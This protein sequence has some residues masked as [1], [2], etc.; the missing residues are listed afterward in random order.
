VRPV[1]L[2]LPLPLL[3][4]LGTLASFAAADRG[5]RAL[6][7]AFASV[8]PLLG[9]P[10]APG[11]PDAELPATVPASAPAPAAALEPAKGRS[12]KARHKPAAP[13]A[14]FVSA[15]T[16]LKVA[17]TR[18][19]L[20]GVP[21]AAEGARPAGLRLSGVAALGVGLL[22]GDVLTRALGVPALSRARVVNAVLVAR[23]RRQK[24]LEGE[25]FRGTERWVIRVEQPYLAEPKSALAEP[26]EPG[27]RLA[28]R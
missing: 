5:A 13:R 4:L 28:S 7:H 19:R 11:E 14:L 1:A 16:V 21:V 8:A 9:E 6:A 10:E 23:A 18:V 2:L 3:A 15:D 17:T 25:F 12:T 26:E 24:I 20:S 27:E 22:D